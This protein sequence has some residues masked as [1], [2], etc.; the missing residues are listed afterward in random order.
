[1]NPIHLILIGD[2]LLSG[3]RRDLHLQTIAK[4]LALHG[5]RVASCDIIHDREGEVEA[6]VRKFLAPDALIVTT[7][8]L[9]PTLDDL[10]REGLSK[11]TG[12]A[13]YEEAELWEDLRQRYERM[14]RRISES[15]R[16]Q[17]MVP[18]KG[19]WFHNDHGT[20]PGLVFEPETWPN[21]TVIALPGPPRELNPMWSEQVLPYLIQR[22][23]WPQPPHSILLRFA[24]M[25]ESSIDEKMRPI[26]AP[27]P[28]IELSSLIRLARVDV[29][30]SLPADYPQAIE[31]LTEIGRQTEHFFSEYVYE[32]WESFNDNQEPPQE[33]E[34]SV[35]R[36]LRQRGE[37]LAVAE[38]C[39]GGLLSS[40]ITDF[41]GSSE[42]FLGG[43]VSYD[44]QLKSNLLGVP[45]EVLVRDGAV[46]ENAVRFMVLG[47]LEA[48]SA[49]W[50][51]AIS[52]V[53]GPGGGTSEKPVGLVWLGIGNRQGIEAIRYEFPGDRDAVRERAAVTAL[54]HLRL[55]LL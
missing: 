25:G 33:L 13:L 50:G 24:Q 19:T 43:I 46:S 15:N 32:R 49:D 18:V 48:T 41:A 42:I 20:A 12:V 23:E 51:I 9:G 22:Y 2:E 27:Y 3:K 17:A 28:E 8:G 7:G 16:S 30:L 11:A 6:C 54:R 31:I 10:T 26:L 36:L 29:T 53:A 14:G 39:T 21:S 52:G 40:W 55:R 35:S 44:N 4:D 47:V 45:A 38:S 5:A 34:Q 37:K 1:M